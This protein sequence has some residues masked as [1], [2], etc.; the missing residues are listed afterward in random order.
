M[1]LDGLCNNLILYYIYLYL[2][3]W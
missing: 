3:R 2:W 1:D